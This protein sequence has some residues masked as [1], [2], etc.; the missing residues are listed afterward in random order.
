MKDYLYSA[1]AAEGAVRIIGAETSGLTEEARKIH[2]TAPTAAAALG[3]VLT[4]AV[5]M[6]KSLKNEEDT[7]TI[8]FRGD[9]PIKCV[10]AVTD[11][12]ANVRGYVG[13]P[14]CD[15]PLN[16]KGK[17]DVGGAVGKGYLNII[18]DLGLKEPYSGTIPLVSGEIAEDLSCYF[19]VS[20]QVPSVVSLGVLV[21]PGEDQENHVVCSGGFI[22]Q[23]LP[24]A[25][26]SLIATLEERVNGL[27]S[28][29]SLLSQGKTVKAIIGELLEGFDITDET[30][31]P[32]EYKCNCSKEKMEKALV[33]LGR[34][35]LKDIIDTQGEAQLTCHFC[36]STHDFTRED[37]QN[38]M[39]HI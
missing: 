1:V 36:G 22:L 33:S 7:M 37:L 2:N 8:Q 6:S 15:L 13:D 24:G 14:S 16:S 26:E 25:Q 35:E 30:E 29:T 32:C 39:A 28:V 27:A 19:A 34:S 20:E 11:A 12:F 18:K 17:L 23:L 38:L 4:A 21:G 31:T 3:R 5:L 10:I 9:G